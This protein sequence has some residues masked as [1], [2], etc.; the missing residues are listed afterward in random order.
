MKFFLIITFLFCSFISVAQVGVNTMTPDP[1]AALEISGI[2]GGFLLA[3]MT[4]LERDA[5]NVSTLSKGLIIYNLDKNVLNI[6]DGIVWHAIVNVNTAT[7]CTTETTY[8]GLLSCLQ[9]NYTPAGTLGYA[10]ARDVM[11]GSIDMNPINLELKGIYTDF[12]I[13]MDYST[14][15]D[16]S[17]HAFNLGI[18]AEHA[19]PQSMGANEEPNRSDMH[20]LF[21][22]KDNV[23]SSRNNCPFGEIDDADADSW[24]VLNTELNSIPSTNIDD[25][26]E[27]D[28]D[29]I[30]PLLDASQQC[31]FE[32]RESKKGDIA[33]AVFYFYTIYN[34]TNVNTYAAYAND[35]FFNSMKNTLILWHIQDPVD[36]DEIDRNVKVKAQQGNDNPFILDQ[37]LVLRLFN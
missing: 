24:Y 33:R 16:A 37:S 6:F 13:I 17:I 26:S 34:N 28:N 31:S 21:P 3:R 35:N 27:K 30:F 14:D 19:Y 8:A 10:T 1:S 29:A 25:Y 12:T 11:Y 2:E 15:P 18:N 32:P 20:S 22:A 9:S 5:V 4:T 7:I 36:Q 23:N